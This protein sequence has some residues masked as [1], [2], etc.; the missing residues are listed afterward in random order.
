MR[1]QQTEQAQRAA[2]GKHQEGV[3]VWRTL[4]ERW[5]EAFIL[6]DLGMLYGDLGEYQRALEAYSQS[7]AS[8][9][10]LN[11]WRGQSQVVNNIGWIYAAL[12]EH[13][14]AIE[15]YE[16]ALQ[17]TRA[18]GNDRRGL[19][20]TLPNIANCHERLG[21]RQKA[22]DYYHQSL[23]L[24]PEVGN[25][26]YTAAA[27]THIGRLPGSLGNP[28][29]VLEYFNQSLELRRTIGDRHGEAATLHQIARLE[30]ERGNLTEARTRIEAALAAVES[31]R[32][33]VASQQLRASFFAS[34]REY[35]EFYLDLLMSL[36]QQRP[37]EGFD[38]LA[39]G[40]SEKGRAHSLLE[41]LKEAR[42]EI[43][44]GV[45]SA[46]LERER[47]LRQLISEKAQQHRNLLSGRHNAEQAAAAE[48]ELNALTTEFEQVQAQIRHNSPRYA[49]LTQPA[50]LSLKEIQSAVLDDDT[51]L[52]EYAL[53]EE[54]SYLWAVTPTSLHSYEL[55]KRA[56]I[57]TAARRVYDALT[58]RNQTPANET[59]EQRRR[60]LDQADAGYPQ[61]AA[62]WSQMLLA[63]VAAQLRAKRLLI[64]SDGVLQYVPFAALPELGARD[65][66]LG[67][68]QQ[69][70]PAAASGG[71]LRAKQQQPPAPSPPAPNCRPRNHQ[72]AFSLRVGRAAAGSRWA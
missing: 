71:G 51:L 49:A 35:H 9:K 40:A 6:H 11:D 31:L 14:K 18:A 2:I 59:P 63:P 56:E 57:E 54:R 52:L 20:I 26:F 68:K 30:R 48:K 67:A 5:M 17:T 16:E 62:A 53:G 66:G 8:Y 45:D 47:G 39:L 44:Q 23:D 28:Q 55:P 34:V 36:H 37:A 60:R 61:A 12:G 27:L 50:P 19:A 32:A 70:L 29:K 15:F 64:V 3:A 21:D 7:R 10:L 25:V 58:V 38:A 13:Q 1:N 4:G 22:L 42:A 33:N 65:W 43:Q 24:M 72:P 41:L 69:Q 46:L